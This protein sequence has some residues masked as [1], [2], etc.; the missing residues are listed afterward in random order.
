[1][2]FTFQ[3]QQRYT[4]YNKYIHSVKY[5]NII[6]AALKFWNMYACE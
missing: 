3:T 2:Y 6:H 4:K 1:M 5:N